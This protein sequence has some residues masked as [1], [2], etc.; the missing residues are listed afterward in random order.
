MFDESKFTQEQLNYIKYEKI[1]DTKLI[2]TAGSGKTRCIVN[3]MSYLIMMKMLDPDEILMLTFSRFTRDDFINK[4]RKLGITNVPEKQIKTIDSFAK[5]LIDENNE[6]DVSLL[7]YKFMK[8]LETATEEEI[9]ANTKLNLVKCVFVDEAQDLNEIQY[10]ILMLLKE[11]NATVINLIGDPN[12]NIYQFRNSSDKFLTNF[13]AETFCLTKNFRSHNPIIEFSKHLRPVKDLDVQGQLGQSECLPNFIFHENDSDLEKY[14]VILIKEAVKQNID[15]SEIAIL[16][17]T[18]GRMM[19]QG[20][21][22]GLCF[23]SNLLYKNKIKFKQ[24]YEEAIDD[25]QTGIRYCPE[26]GH[27][28]LLTYMGS[29][30]LEW[31]FVILVDA[32]VC[33]INKRQFSDSKHKNDQYLLYVA[34]SRA[35]TNM[36]IFS[37]YKC[38][39]G[40]FTFQLN[41]WFKL[42]PKNCY[43]MDQRLEKFFKYPGINPKDMVDNEKRTTKLLDKLGEEL[44]DELATICKYGKIDKIIEKIYDKDYSVT[45][46]SNLFLGKYVENLFRVY[47]CMAA[48]KPK[49]VYMDI[50]NIINKSIITNVPI[51]VSEWFYRNRDHIT[52]E[53]YDEQKGENSC[54][55]LDKVITDCVDKLFNRDQP[56][57][58]HTIVND[59]YFKSFILTLRDKIEE[60]YNKYKETTNT[61]KVKK[62]L[63]DIMILL[64]SLETQ[65][66]FHA[67]SKGKKF[68]EIL[69]VCDEMFDSIKKYAYET[70]MKFESNNVAIEKDGLIGE[71][72]LIDDNGNIWEVKCTSDISLKHVLQVLMY[73]LL[74]NDYNKETNIININFINFLKGEKIVF[75]I[76]LT[77]K[78]INRIKEIFGQIGGA[79][80]I[81]SCKKDIMV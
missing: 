58:S 72:D 28:N 13:N 16:S 80:V 14:L 48:N 67:L 57:Q 81:D 56:L 42:I 79:H 24:F 65:H 20:R 38:H 54:D 8:Y 36:V 31:K 59:G 27:V 5:T 43:S 74:R 37:K 71:V 21:S 30:G 7:S 18:R 6:I 50:Q 34:C 2:A 26:K 17:P 11:K 51:M 78:D 76:S 61:Q 23:I 40:N 32:D 45:I 29:K 55:P 49:P 63:F 12:Q 70:T 39:E 46:S 25:Q 73:N 3:R 22:H 4:I 69:I 75:P 47:Y 9:K 1:K 53:K 44:L 62:Y 60:N 52:W 35:V 66:Y 77:Q 10:K 41:P 68:K 15:A 64:Y 19:G 33:L